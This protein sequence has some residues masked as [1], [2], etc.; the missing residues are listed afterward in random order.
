MH[1]DVDL[2]LHMFSKNTFPA[3]LTKLNCT[4]ILRIPILKISQYLKHCK[5]WY[6]IEFNG[7]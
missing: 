7:L 3:F 2:R 4:S 1:N 6:L 5:F